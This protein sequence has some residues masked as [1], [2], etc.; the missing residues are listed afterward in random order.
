MNYDMKIDG[1]G[2]KKVHLDIATKVP[3]NGG[4]YNLIKN[5]WWA[6]TDDRCILYYKNARQCN[7]NKIIVEH[8]IKMENHP[9]KTVEFL[10]NVWEKYER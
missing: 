6:V 1:V 4:V 9:A 2:F 3:E 10:E 7:I 5:R 8:I